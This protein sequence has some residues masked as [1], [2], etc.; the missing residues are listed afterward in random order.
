MNHP[1]CYPKT[2][3][4]EAFRLSEAVLAASLLAHARAWRR[5]RSMLPDSQSGC[6][7]MPLHPLLL[8]AVTTRQ[9][10]AGPCDGYYLTAGL[11]ILRKS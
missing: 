11:P 1:A 8:V 9:L 10:L 7:A 2:V 5:H 3:A 6:A 4:F